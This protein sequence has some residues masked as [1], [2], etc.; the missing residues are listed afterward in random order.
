MKESFNNPWCWK[1]GSVDRR[2]DHI[3]ISYG[4]IHKTKPEEWILAALLSLP[5][6]FTFTVEF[7][8]D[9]LSEKNHQITKD[10]RAELDYYLVEK[11]ERNPWAYCQDHCSTSAN[12]YSRVHWSYFPKSLNESQGFK[13]K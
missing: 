11:R 3:E 1:I 9:T 4:D 7:M 10:V 12:V 6:E 2:E 5:A 13:N 8:I